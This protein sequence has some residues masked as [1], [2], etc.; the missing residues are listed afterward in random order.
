M[1]WRRNQ[2]V[3]LI[4]YD[5]FSLHWSSVPIVRYQFPEIMAF[6]FV[7]LIVLI[8]R[9]VA[10][11][12]RDTDVITD[13]LLGNYIQADNPGTSSDLASEESPCPVGTAEKI[14]ACSSQLVLLASSGYPWEGIPYIPR[15][16]YM[17]C[18]IYDH[19]C[20]WSAWVKVTPR[21]DS[22]RYSEMS[23]FARHFRVASLEKG[24]GVTF[25]QADHMHQW[26]YISH[27]I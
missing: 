12:I 6:F 3:M 26:S 7:F 9:S 10:Y 15:S 14:A 1:H 27:G 13:Q 2:I 21:N 8:P 19:W 16:C 17:P 24:L 22:G 4:V 23:R 11:S 25:T 18:D 20:M 5:S